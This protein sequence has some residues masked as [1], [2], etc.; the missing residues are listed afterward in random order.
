MAAPIAAISTQPDGTSLFLVGLDTG[1]RGG[2]QVWTNTYPVNGNWGG[3]RP[4][5]GNIFPVGAPIAA[6]SLSR[7]ATSL[8]LVGFDNE[9]LGGGHVWTKF[10]P[11]PQRGGGW[12][13]WLALGSEV[14]PV[15][16]PVTAISTVEGGTSLYVV[17]LDN[18]RRGGGRVWTKAFPDANN[19]NDWGPWRPIGEN[20][21]PPGAR[22]SAIS[23]SHGATSLYVPGL[24]GQV[25][26]TFFPAEDVR[27]ATWFALGPNTFVR[28]A[29][30]SV[31]STVP[32]GTSLFVPG[33]DGQI[34]STYYDLRS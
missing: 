12:S 13:D 5:G 22:V 6:L 24:D 10:F 1:G 19:P 28:S 7:G 20:V 2:G 33:T 9:G 16:A 31:V 26:S 17:G 4:L 8:Y 11:D 3:W 21:F 32:G 15:G 18:E 25:W 34:W 29:Q 23:L 30:I 14:F 27:W